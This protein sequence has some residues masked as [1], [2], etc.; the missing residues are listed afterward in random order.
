MDWRSDWLALHNRIEGVEK[1][2]DL[3]LHSLKVSNEDPYGVRKKVFRP[4]FHSIAGA[5]RHFRAVHAKS[6]PSTAVE[7]IDRFLSDHGKMIENLELDNYGHLVACVTALSGF[8]GEL[9]FLLT[10]RSASLLRQT[11]RAIAH[12]QRT[13]VAD[14]PAQAKWRE[15][16]T[17]GEIACERLGAVHLLLHGIWAFKTSA[18]GE[19]TDLIYGEPVREDSI[20]A[21]EGLVL[22]EWKLVRMTS[23]VDSKLSEAEAQAALYSA[24]ILGGLELADS[25]FIIAVSL[26]RLPMPA[27]EVRAG[28]VYRR[29]NIAV[30]ASTPSV[31]ARK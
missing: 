31:T 19:R 23:E 14:P 4:A 29:R 16:Y 7:G 26:D 10:D 2:F 8:R 22:T 11:E 28:V 9:R 18:A 21:A 20:A 5:I 13:L 17:S 25:R 15:A 3:Y 6:L 24:G 1:S 27:D 12:L 30:A